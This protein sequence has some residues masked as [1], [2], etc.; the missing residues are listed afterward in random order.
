MRFYILNCFFVQFTFSWTQI[1]CRKFIREK[2]HTR[3][4][5]ILEKIERIEN[6]PFLFIQDS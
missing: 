2:R 3:S 1:L 4:L 6:Y 5:Y